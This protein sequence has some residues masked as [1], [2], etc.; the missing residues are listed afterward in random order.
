M[1][2]ILLI[3][4]VLISLVN[5]KAQQTYPLNTFYK[6]APNYS[7]MK[8]LN[9][10][11]PPYM[12]TYKATY[13]GNEIT[14]YITKEDHLLHDRINRK[15]YKDVLRVKY[16]VKKISTGVILQSTQN[17]TSSINEIISMGTNAMDNNSI[18]LAYSGTNCEVGWGRITL[19][20]INAT[21]ISW[22][23]YANS[24]LLSDGDCPGNPDIKVYLPD[25]KNLVFTKQ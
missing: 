23:Y 13:Q 18:D 21:Q 16:T 4:T 25:T 10:D 7:Y 9:N 24:T 11:L 15:F 14:L 19:K 2:K 17:T 20:K 22:S 6:D 5:C 12:G 1:K 3:F 8:D